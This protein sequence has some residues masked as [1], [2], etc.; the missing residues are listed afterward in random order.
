MIVVVGRKV[1]LP[2]SPCAS[3]GQAVP[4]S[5]SCHLLGRDFVQEKGRTGAQQ[6]TREQG[7]Q[8]GDVLTLASAGNVAP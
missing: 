7:S 1:A 8:V 2:S 4:S 3:F 6:H 5:R